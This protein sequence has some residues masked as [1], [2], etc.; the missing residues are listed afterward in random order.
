MDPLNDA[1]QYGGKDHRKP[2]RRENSAIPAADR[3]RRR[4]GIRWWEAQAAMQPG[5]AELKPDPIT[6]FVTCPDSGTAESIARAVVAE[7]L[8]ACANLLPGMR[9]IYRWQGAVEEATEVVLLLK[10]RRDLFDRLERRIRDLHP[11][12]VPCIVAWPI[13]AGHKPYLE[14][15]TAETI[16]P[17][18]SE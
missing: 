3:E 11:Y 18:E 2:C 9:S 13:I 7:G 14:W 6:V 10:S 15:L 12:D 17:E 8:A 16:A 5:G 1:R 4:G